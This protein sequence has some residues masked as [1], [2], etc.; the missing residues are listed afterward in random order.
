MLLSWLFFHAQLPADL[1]A[2]LLFA[3]SV[4]LS[5]LVRVTF[6]FCI[7]LFACYTLN[8]RGLHWIQW[9]VVSI[10]SGALIPLEFFPD[11][12]KTVAGFLPFQAIISTPLNIYLGNVQGSA[13]WIAIGLQGFWVFVLWLLGRLLLNRSL[14]ALEIQGG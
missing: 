14:Q 7:S 12:L 10:F 11:W 3:L 9:G 8:G 5:F 1:A 6:D 4:V 2:A 13:A